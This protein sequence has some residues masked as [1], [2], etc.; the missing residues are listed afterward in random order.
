MEASYD[1]LPPPHVSD[2]YDDG[3]L[4][5]K[6]SKLTKLLE[7]AHCLQYS[8]TTTIDSLQNNPDALAAVAHT[9]HE[10]SMLVTKMGPSVLPFLKTGFPAVA[11]LL[12]SPQF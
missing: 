3:E 9:P 12:V 6:A 4:R 2:K 7:E 11:A 10:I 1:Q 5:E 8:I